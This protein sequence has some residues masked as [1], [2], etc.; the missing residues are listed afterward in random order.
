MRGRRPK[1]QPYLG[2][3]QPIFGHRYSGYSGIRWQ[4][5]WQSCDPYA[6]PADGHTVIIWGHFLTVNL[7][8]SY[9]GANTIA[10][11]TL[12]SVGVMKVGAKVPGAMPDCP[13]RHQLAGS[14]KSI[15]Q[16]HFVWNQ[17]STLHQQNMTHL[18]KCQDYC[19]TTW[20]H[21]LPRNLDVWKKIGRGGGNEYKLIFAVI[22]ALTHEMM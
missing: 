22:K 18:W 11:L 8:L 17:C 9:P 21:N 4:P 19:S 5:P 10:L 2:E 3:H 20:L 6:Y 7:F 12:L 15:N 16:S 14:Y 1:I 13:C